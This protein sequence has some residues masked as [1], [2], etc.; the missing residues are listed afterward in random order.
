MKIAIAI[1]AGGRGERMGMDKASLRFH[2]TTLLERAAQTAL[3]TL[4]TA[5]VVGRPRPAAWP[6]EGL[7]FLEDETPGAGPLGGLATALRQSGSD[8]VLAIACDMPRLTADALRWLLAAARRTPLAHGLIVVNGPRIEP[9][10]SLYTTRCLPLI[11]Q[12]RVSGRR[13]LHALIHAGDFARLAAPPEIAAALV[14]V[15]TPEEFAAL[16][17]GEPL[18]YPG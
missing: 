18:I 1:L 15:N 2:G 17:G 10:F 16:G 5:L 13:S 4:P 12:Q 9:L 7:R 6:L 3:N 11:D 8:A 14:N